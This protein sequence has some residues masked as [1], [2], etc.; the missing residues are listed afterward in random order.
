MLLI[1][2]FLYLHL[3]PSLSLNQESL[4]LQTAKLSLSDP[5]GLLS[6]WN[7]TTS[8]TPCKWTGVTCNSVNSVTSLNLPSVS[9]SGPFPISLCNLPSLSSLSLPNNS[10]NSSLPSTIST[11]RNLTYL[12]LSQNNVEGPIP[13]TLAEIPNLR[14]LNLDGNYL[15]GEIPASFG[16]FRRLEVLILTG[17]LLGGSIPSALGNITTL[18]SLDLA[19]NP[20]S[21]GR[22]PPELGNL[23]N[24]EDFWLSDCN[25][26]GEFPASF[27]RMSQLTNLDVSQNKLTGS[28]PNLIFQFSNAVQILLYN[29]SFTSELPVNGW[30]NLTALIN[31]DASMNMLTGTIPTELCELKLGSLNL[32]ENQLEGVIPE[33]IAKSPNLYE[34]KL[35]NNRLIG[36]LPS[37]LGMNSPLKTIDVSGNPLSGRIPANLCKKGVLEELILIYSSFS[38]EIPATLGACWSLTRV[39]MRSNRLWGKVPAGLWGLP[40]INLLDLRENSFSGKISDRIS[41]AFNLSTLLISQN[42]FSG[43]LPNEIGSLGNLIEFSVSDN[44]LTGQIPG[45][46]VRLDQLVKLDLSNN[47]ISGEIPVGIQSMNQLNELNLANNML[48]GKIPDEI[49]DLLVLNYLDLSQNHLSGNIPIGLQNLKLNKLN[50]SSNHLTG[51]IPPLYAKSSYKNSFVGNP[52]LCGDPS[53]LCPEKGRLKHHVYLWILRS[54]YIIAALIFV[55]GVAWF[56][57]KYQKF[58]N[59]EKGPATWKWR[60]FHKLGFGEFE[61]LDSLSEDNFI[62]SGGSGKVYKVVLSNG[63]VVAVKKMKDETRVIDSFETE[64]DTLGKIRHKN[65]MRLWCCCNNGDYKLL[66]YEYMQNGSLADLLHGSKRSSGLLEYWPTRLK[67]AL[68]AAEGIAYLH[69]DCVPSIIHRD[70]KSS[71]ILL[72]AEF[73]A[74]I[75]DFGVA[76]MIR[77][78]SNGPESMSAIAGS[79]GYIAPEYAYTLRVNEKSDIYSFGVVLLELVTGRPPVDQIFGEK[80]LATWVC[81]TLDR[82]GF[83]RMLDPTLDST[84][85]DQIS[86]VLDI[87]L[88]CIRPLPINR[89][90]MK[91][92]VKMLQD[93]GADNKPKVPKKD[94]KLSPYYYDEDGSSQV[95]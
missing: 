16:H 50:L 48:S 29:N 53:D 1:L 95:V 60:S 45:T 21:H 81:T 78:V 69:H 58:K 54:I 13:P 25:L 38:G 93:V 84:Y 42:Q 67:I 88:R 72:D 46:V 15:S 66:V 39:R 61:I 43:S 19:Y 52:G 76:K 11:C 92:V 27:A 20:F 75:S 90:S 18:K 36:S 2:L 10:L 4:S 71:N 82:E 80:D 12:D 73:G 89:P 51:E 26:V 3:P 9:L 37:D 86:K 94:G 64:V 65:I 85:K 31:F 24:L 23:S 56:L 14:Y 22:I 7:P 33:S 44:K 30:T 32:F 17:N 62:G 91:R 70:V 47:Q 41:G 57:L 35:F 74:R 40:N 5:T 63:E 8:A 68:D 6:N 83:D 49:G 34:L 55:V 79:C 77:A 87:G 28:I 59:T